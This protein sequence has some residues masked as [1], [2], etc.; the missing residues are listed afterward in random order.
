[1]QKKQVQND[2]NELELMAKKLRFLEESNS[3]LISYSG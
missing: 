1:M 3:A 2:Q